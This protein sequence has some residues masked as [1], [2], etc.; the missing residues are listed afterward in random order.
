MSITELYADYLQYVANVLNYAPATVRTYRYVLGVF[1]QQ[2]T[3]PLESIT[4]QE[5]DGYF[6]SLNGTLSPASQNTERSIIRSFLMYC[7]RYRGIRLLFDYSMIRNIKVEQQKI[8]FVTLEE[9]Q[10]I[11]SHLKNK[12]DRL[13]VALLFASAMR[14]GELVKFSVE[15]FYIQEITVRGKGGKK[16]VLPIH[17]EISLAI[18][19]HILEHNIQTGPIFR[20]VVPKKGN[21][22]FTVSGLRKRLERQLKPFGLYKS[23]HKFRHGSATILLQN[24][25]DIRSVQVLL[26]HSHIATTMRYTHVTDKHLQESYLKCFPQA[27]MHLD[28]ILTKP[29]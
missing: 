25:M 23:P 5:V 29:N 14:I 11:A 4:L 1:T 16:R 20:H 28:K 9:L 7:D 22:C 21:T 27:A 19:E 24:G 13:I 3:E 10:A 15:D 8:E 26:G 18:S 2:L 6:A 12:Q 17:P